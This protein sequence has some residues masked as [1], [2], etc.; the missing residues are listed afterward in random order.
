MLITFV[1]L[2]QNYTVI[3]SDIHHDDSSATF[4]RRILTKKAALHFPNFVGK[5]NLR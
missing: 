3:N 2:R 1:G 4:W 5:P